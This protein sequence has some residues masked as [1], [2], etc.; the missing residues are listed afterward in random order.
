M[1]K[2]KATIAV[3][4]LALLSACGT[5]KGVASDTYGAGKFVVRQITNNE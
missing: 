5:V 4:I 2:A 1:N 3:V